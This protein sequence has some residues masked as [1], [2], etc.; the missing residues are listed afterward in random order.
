MAIIQWFRIL[1]L[2]L[3]VVVIVGCS[4]DQTKEN[5]E[6]AAVGV[7]G[8]GGGETT[9]IGENANLSATDLAGVN[10]SERV[11]NP[12]DRMTESFGKEFDDPATLLSKRV[13]YFDYDNTDVSLEY[14]PIISAHAGYLAKNPKI[15]VILEG[16]TDERGSR[17]YNL[18]LG[19]RRA[20][21]VRQFMQLNVA[22]NQLEVVSYG[23]ERPASIGH[24]E[25]AWR[26]NRRVEIVYRRK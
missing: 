5:A 24:E 4:T 1:F 19:E 7:G 16:H 15:T 2:A 14:Q 25:A 6:S 11:Y 10:K 13:I 9:G 23:E 17:E 18:A 8:T 3:P 22:P 21:I 20:Q 26:L 12:E